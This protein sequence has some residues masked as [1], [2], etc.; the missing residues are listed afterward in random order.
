MRILYTFVSL[1]KTPTLMKKNKPIYALVKTNEE[2]N[3]L[4][5]TLFT[6]K[7]SARE[8]MKKEYRE[9]VADLVASGYATS[10]RAVSEIGCYLG[11]DQATT[12]M[13]VS[14]T[15]YNWTVV[16]T[17]YSK[18][19]WKVA[20]HRYVMSYS[21]ADGAWMVVYAP[22]LEDAERRWEDGVYV[23]EKDA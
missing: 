18:L 4:N 2:E 16:E 23:L 1:N 21:Q 5:V 8:Q 22:S 13:G 9:E 6:T 10:A 14:E 20:N 3:I 12:G 11:K 7:T 19:F 15:Y 17:E